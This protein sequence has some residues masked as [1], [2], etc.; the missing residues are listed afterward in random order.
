VA[1]PNVQEMVQTPLPAAQEFYHSL[2]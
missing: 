1:G 2:P